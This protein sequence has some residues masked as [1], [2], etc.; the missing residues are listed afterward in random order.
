MNNP[1]SNPMHNP[2]LDVSGLPHFSAI[3]AEHLRP[4]IEHVLTHNRARIAA[5]IAQKSPYTWDNFVRPLEECNDYLN[6]VWSPGDHLHNVA[7]NEELRQAYNECLLLLSHYRAEISHNKDLY[8]A[9]QALKNSADYPHLS[10]AQQ[11]TIENELLDFHLGGVDLPAEQKERYKTIQQQLSQLTSQFGQNLLDATHA[12]KKHITQEQDLAG[13]PETLKTLLRHKA[14]EENLSGWL[15]SLEAPIYFPLINYADKRDLR[16]EL[17]RAFFTRASALGSHSGQWDNTPL[18]HKILQLRYEL[19]QLL[20]YPNYAAYSLVKKMARDTEHV[21]TFLHDLAQRA[22]PLALRE[23]DELRAFA[24]QYDGTDG[25]EMWDVP[26]YSEKLRQHRYNIAQEQLRPY[27]PLPRVVQGLF[28]I[29]QRLYGLEVRQCD[30]VDVWHPDIHFYEIRDEHGDIRGQFYLDPYARKGKRS[31][32]WMADAITRTVRADGSIQIPVAYLN[33]NFTP[34]TEDKPALLTHQEVITLF[35]EFGHG[36][37]HML[38]RIEYSSVSGIN[39]VAWDAVELPSQLMENWCWEREALDLFARHYETD[40]PLP[41]DLLDKMLA[42]KNFQAGLFMVRQLEFALFDFRLHLEYQP[43]W[44]AEKIREVL[45]SVR[46]EVAALFPPEFNRSEN[47]FQHVFAGG[48]AAGYYSY[49][50]AEVLSA[51]VFSR[52]EQQGIFDR[53]TGRSFMQH[54]LE[55]GGSRPAMT[56]FQDFQGREPAIEPLLR[57]AGFIT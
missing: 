21:M 17:Y 31:G 40:A 15:L 13:L 39:G 32:A 36:L 16:E 2:L 46:C 54:I 43:Q 18:I 12:W 26:Y 11:T 10:P 25:L 37:H 45:E 55:Q 33:C 19:A 47:Q 6:R 29:I 24:R 14:K 30:G 9:Y 23:L 52:F 53:D 57:K 8:L 49:K 3:R 5:L 50:W 48:Y 28:Q 44:G 20:G 7:D 42:A 35:H 27:F 41:E 1:M 4:A 34:P 22:R 51:D 38:T 56:L